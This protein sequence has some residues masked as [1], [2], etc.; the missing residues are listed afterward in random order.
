MK[1]LS[2]SRTQYI[3]SKLLQSELVIGGRKNHYVMLAYDR[4]HDDAPRVIDIGTH[5]GMDR[6]T[7]DQ[8]KT[9]FL[10]PSLCFD[11]EVYASPGR[12]VP[13]I[14]FRPLV[15]AW[16]LKEMYGSNPPIGRRRVVCREIRHLLL[17]GEVKH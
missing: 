8:G 2:G 17:R 3:L 10:H 5:P 14:L 6:I 1:R 7:R 12:E 13:E 15:C 11:L 9:Y 16:A 4:K